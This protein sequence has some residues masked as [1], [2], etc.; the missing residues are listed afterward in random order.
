[1]S[2]V[3]DDIIKQA[4]DYLAG[5]Y[6]IEETDTIP[7]PKDVPFGKKAKLMQLCAFCIDMRGSTKLLLEHHKQTAV[8]YHKAFLYATA[9]VVL[10][11]GG[12][13][14]SYNGDSL[15]AFWPAKTKGQI[16]DCVKAAM[17]AKW[18]LNDKLK[19]NFDEY[20][21]IDFGIG[22][23]WGDVLIARAGVARDANN[24]DLIFIGKCVN[25]AVAI[26]DSACGSHHIGISTST[27]DNL[28]D[29]LI[30]C[31]KE[32]GSKV[33]MWSDWSITWRGQSHSLKHTS[34][35]WEF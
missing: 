12:I 11:K 24:N 19:S 3:S 16:S 21:A 30:Y 34:Y 17:N 13:I 7:E 20:Q 10:N 1:M 14:R 26:A 29:E 32:D 27:Y 28:T 6:E 15:L 22:I 35:H 4:K 5:D 23:D 18:L 2:T 33:N 9:K 31:P 25:Y 8:K